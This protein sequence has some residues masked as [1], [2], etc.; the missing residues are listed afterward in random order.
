MKKDGA[1]YYFAKENLNFQRLESQYKEG[2]GTDM[3]WPKG[4]GKLKTIAQIFKEQGG[5]EELGTIKG[6]VWPPITSRTSA[7]P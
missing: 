6:A 4:V 2:F 7:S 3:P 1:V 5:F